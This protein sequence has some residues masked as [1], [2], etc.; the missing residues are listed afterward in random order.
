MKRLWFTVLVAGILA[1][2]AIPA[3]AQEKGEE[4]GSPPS[5]GTEPMPA[6][7]GLFVEQVQL[8]VDG[9]VVESAPAGQQVSAKVTIRNSSE[10]SA[11]DVSMTLRPEEGPVSIVDASKAFGDIAAGGSATAVYLL[12]V[13]EKDC[14]EF[15]GMAADITSSLGDTPSKIGFPAA[16]PGPRLYVENVRYVG[17][18]GDQLPEPGERLQIY[19]T[20]RN[21][22]RDAATDVRGT[23]TIANTDVKVVDASAPWPTVAPGE[24]GE[25][26]SPFVIEIADDAD[27][28]QPCEPMTGGIVVDEPVQ[29]DGDDSVSSDGTVSSDGSTT[30]IAPAPSSEPGS[31]VDGSAGSTEPAEGSG[32][33]STGSGTTE[34]GVIEPEPGTSTEPDPDRPAPDEQPLPDEGTPVPFEAVLKVSASGSSTDLGF[35]SGLYCA[36]AAE[37]RPTDGTG[38][39]DLGAP[40]AGAPNSD[41]QAA[42]AKRSSSSDEGSGALAAVILAMVASLA[43]RFRFNV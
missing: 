42:A 19:V 36:I 17:G 15:I 34:P 43:L 33:G 23:V 1:A 8:S 14:S 37:G 3:Q 32:G 11:N 2:S 12:T 10:K 18:D 21:H 13:S 4:P 28:S 30:Q 22:G 41:E 5:T 29:R 25:N 39:R 27:I 38:S 31:G 26:S 7:F 24:S 20:L 40:I 35:G 6:E 9:K 16:C